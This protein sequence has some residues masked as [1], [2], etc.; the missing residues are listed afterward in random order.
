MS[1][2]GN[3]KPQILSWR[4]CPVGANFQF[5]QVNSFILQIQKVEQI[6]CS[7]R[8]FERLLIQPDNAHL[9][10]VLYK[11]LLARVKEVN[12]ARIKWQKGL[13]S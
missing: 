7:P 1:Q 10:S 2:G 12:V 11:L 4:Q 3:A 13:T 9:L 5:I 6:A 8:E